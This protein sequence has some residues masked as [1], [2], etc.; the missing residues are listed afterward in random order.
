[1]SIILLWSLLVQYVI[2]FISFLL[3][4]RWEMVIYWLGAIL[5]QT[6]IIMI[7]KK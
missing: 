6:S 3:H 2:I 7:L 4:K 1:M 5:I